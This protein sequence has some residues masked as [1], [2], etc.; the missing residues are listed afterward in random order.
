MSST[1]YRI[2]EHAKEKI[3][4]KIILLQSAQGL[5]FSPI[6][7]L[8]SSHHDFQPVQLRNP[9]QMQLEKNIKVKD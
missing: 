2:T 9:H 6:M 7:I 4:F 1:N 5:G 8:L 3:D